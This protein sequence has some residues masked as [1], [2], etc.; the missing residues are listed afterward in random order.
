MGKKRRLSVTGSRSG[1]PP[2]QPPEYVNERGEVVPEPLPELSD[3]A[4]AARKGG[5]PEDVHQSIDDAVRRSIYGMAG[6]LQTT[7]D[8]WISVSSPG[9]AERINDAVKPAVD[10]LWRAGR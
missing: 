10:A 1:A 3:E 9:Y 5:T 2:E 7:L 6:V 8:I 4:S